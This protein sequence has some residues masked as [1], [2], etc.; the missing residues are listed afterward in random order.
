MQDTIAFASDYVAEKVTAKH[1]TSI[2]DTLHTELE[3]SLTDGISNPYLGSCFKQ[4]AHQILQNGGSFEVC[5][6]D[7][8]RT[9]LQTFP[10]EKEI[11]RFSTIDEIKD[12][13]YYRLANQKFP[14]IDAILAPKVL[15]QMTIATK[16]PIEMVGLKRLYDKLLKTEDIQFF[17]VVPAQL[18]DGFQKQKFIT[19]DD[20][21]LRIP[22]WIKNHV[23]QYVLKIDLS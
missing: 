20:D 18:Y 14:T 23:K 6:L 16:H 10:Q 2:L 9:C 15:F 13:K 1:K 3:L 19:T 21:P 11:F 17:F 4:M 7:D 8:S 12:G 22:V 5:S